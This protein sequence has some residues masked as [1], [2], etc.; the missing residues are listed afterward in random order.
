MLQQTFHWH[1][2]QSTD[3]RLEAL[4]ASLALAGL[5]LE[6]AVPLIAALLELPLDSKYPPLTMPPEQQRKR[7]LAALAAWT[8][9]F[10]KVQPLVMATEDLHWADPSTLEFIQLAGEQ[11]GTAPLMLLHTAGRSFGFSGHCGR[12]IRS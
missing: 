3:R 9:G 1:A 4:E 2:N 6:E 10:A 12:I 7:L 8:I 5:K 11:G